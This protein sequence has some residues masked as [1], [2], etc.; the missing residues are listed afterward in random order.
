[1][2]PCRLNSLFFQATGT[3]SYSFFLATPPSIQSHVNLFVDLLSTNR[4]AQSTIHHP[5]SDHEHHVMLHPEWVVWLCFVHCAFGAS[6]L[7]Y[8]P[9]QWYYAASGFG[10][11][12]Y[13]WSYYYIGEDIYYVRY[14]P[15]D[16][17]WFSHRIDMK[18]SQGKNRVCHTISCKTLYCLHAESWPYFRKLC[19]VV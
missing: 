3:D 16:T 19:C 4:S 11:T 7:P 8:P 14:E 17:S 6:R 18:N 12:W 15:L 10:I 9:N 5:S 13:N 2:G 1:M